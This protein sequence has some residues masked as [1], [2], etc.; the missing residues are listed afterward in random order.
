M[1]R[2]AALAAIIAATLL[3]RRLLRDIEE[4]RA[5]DPNAA[6]YEFESWGV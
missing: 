1:S 6:D 3:L 5:A 4:Q 2:L